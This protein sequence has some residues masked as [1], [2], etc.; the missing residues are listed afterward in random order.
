MG[1]NK[2]KTLVNGAASMEKKETHIKDLQRKLFHYMK[3]F[4]EEK[5]RR[6]EAE[7]RAEKAEEKAH[8]DYLTSLLNYRALI[9]EFERKDSKFKRFQTT[10]G[11]LVFIDLDGFKSF[12]DRYGQIKGNE[13]LKK[14]GETIKKN[15]RKY[16]EVYRIGGDEFVIFLDEISSVD[17]AF[18]VAERVREAIAGIDMGELGIQKEEHITA[19]V[20]VSSI[21]G[22]SLEEIIKEA[23]TAE[24]AAKDAGKNRTFIFG[25][26]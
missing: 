23:N 2:N 19:S 11:Y 26:D 4:T 18:N 5:I 8:E 22:Q 13:I 6:I 14:V 20:G 24:K 21:N 12:N 17:I 16:D 15:I 25:K 10:N 9:R 1:V 7:K 3:M